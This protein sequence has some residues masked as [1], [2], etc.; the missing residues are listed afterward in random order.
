MPNHTLEISLRGSGRN[1]RGVIVPGHC[2]VAVSDSVTWDAL[3]T[4]AVLFFPNRQ[5]FG[6][7]DVDISAGNSRTLTVQDGDPVYESGKEQARERLEELN[8][9]HDIAANYVQSSLLPI[10]WPQLDRGEL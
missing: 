8:E 4:D 2:R 7:R 9:E 10:Q 6:R 5:L 1:R 3:D